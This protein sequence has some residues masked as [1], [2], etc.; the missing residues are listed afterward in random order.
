MLLLRVFLIFSCLNCLAYNLYSGDMNESKSWGGSQSDSALLKKPSQ[1]SD[2]RGSGSASCSKLPDG[3]KWKILKRG[4]VHRRVHHE[5]THLAMAM[6]L[7]EDLFDSIED[8]SF[9]NALKKGLPGLQEQYV[10]GSK[11][12]QNEAQN[13]L[14]A[15][16]ELDEQT[17]QI[18]MSEVCWKDQTVLASAGNNG[19]SKLVVAI[20]Q[21]GKWPRNFD[22]SGV[23]AWLDYCLASDP[24]LI[25]IPENAEWRD[26][27]T[28]LQAKLLRID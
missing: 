24:A 16:A 1:E 10:T 27:V 22:R 9:F 20:L 8:L 13:K 25:N 28:Q 19:D 21:S 11:K 14:L 12:E 6:E 17:R 3:S 4:V 18:F 23:N 26:T 2:R 15:L 5:P 7:E